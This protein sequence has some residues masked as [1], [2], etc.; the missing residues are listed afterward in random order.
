MTREIGSARVRTLAIIAAIAAIPW[1]VT[2]VLVYTVHGASL[3]EFTPGPQANDETDYWHMIATYRQVGFGGGHYTIEERTAA[4]PVRFGV[5]GPV[6]PV[7]Y[8]T[9][10]R[11]LGWELASAPLFHLGFISAA[12]ALFI[13][14]VKL[15][16]TGLWLAALLFATYC[17]LL[18]FVQTNM[19]EGLHYAIAI[20]LAGFFLRVG[21]EQNSRR[22]IITTI[23]AIVLAST[24]RITWALLLFPLAIVA[25]ES[26]GV[27]ALGRAL[28]VALIGAGVLWL[29][30]SALN[31]PYEAFWTVATISGKGPSALLRAW[32]DHAV[33]NLLGLVSLEDSW[34]ETLQ[35]IQIA[36][37]LVGLSIEM[38][39]RPPDTRLSMRLLHLVNLGGAYLIVLPFYIVG[40]F[41]DYRLLSVHLLFSL[42]LLIAAAD[43]GLRRI[44]LF[45]ITSELL[46]LPIF[47]SDYRHWWRPAYDGSDRLAISSFRSQVEDKLVFRPR[48]EP[49]CNTLG[50]LYEAPIGEPVDFAGV[51]VGFGLTW[52][53]PYRAREF[54]RR[55]PRRPQYLLMTTERYMKLRLTT[56]IQLL[57]EVST[58]AGPAALCL[59]LESACKESYL[60]KA[61]GAESAFQSL[62]REP[63]R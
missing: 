49:W 36:L 2:I 17:P 43:G 27:L 47:L 21:Q 42:L 46:I 20:I 31:A 55:D 8:G 52:Y 9:I 13:A 7:L 10:G 6:L 61:R 16:Q 28:S 45:M 44:A 19:Q 1:V 53:F 29:S 5:Y 50:V 32:T 38:V 37:L 4:V 59:N 63:K 26:K 11:L 14:T 48:A 40:N 33:T 23:I 22:W 34:I 18:R 41:G 3:L 30:T 12:I 35:R 51:P 24:L 58:S 54:E 15:N 62:R 56:R 60:E 25:T 57:R 39:L